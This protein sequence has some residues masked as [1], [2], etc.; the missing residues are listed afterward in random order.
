MLFAIYTLYRKFE[1][2]TG[3]EA[4]FLDLSTDDKVEL[5]K[6]V[7]PFSTYQELGERFIAFKK[8]ADHKFTNLEVG[9]KE[10]VELWEN[11]VNRSMQDFQKFYDT[12]NIHQDYVI[13]ESFYADKGKKIILENEKSW[14][15]CLFTSEI[16]NQQI[17]LL[18]K[19]LDGKTI[20]EK[21]FENT[22][23]EIENDIGSYVVILDNF[24]RFIVLKGN[25]SSIYATRDIWAIN[26]RIQ[27]F[28]PSKIVYVVGQEQKDHFNKLFEFT[29]SISSNKKT[30]FQHI[31]FWFYID[32]ASKKKLSSR[33]WASN[34][35]K[36]LSESIR[37]FKNKYKDND[38]FWEN[39]KD[40]IAKA[41]WVGSIV[42]NDIKKDKKGPVLIDKDLNKTIQ[43]FEEAWWAYII[44]ASC[45]AKSILKRYG[46]ELPK[47]HDVLPEKLEDIEINLI[48]KINQFP[49]IIQQAGENN[50]PAVLA[51]FLY[52][53]AR[54]YNAYYTNHQVLKGD[55][56]HRLLITKCVAQV[57]D[58][59]MKI[60]HIQPLERI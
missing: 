46:K 42:Y 56:N 23:R 13:G 47:L 37:Y 60:C 7:G 55:N 5:Q 33:E 27:G 18:Q 1:K 20:S 12:L 38:E 10:E 52:T 30:D 44:Y 21:E 34:V 29:N 14:K 25:Q 59:G 6:F 32:E 51:E 49:L 11:I 54:E 4:E 22:K 50:D 41:L 53:I 36:I 31:Y 45:R 28:D 15:V 35:N 3:S 39:E 40:T 58:N 9:K 24:E 57:I 2:I 43:K 17:K 16:A 26:Y 19:Q 8:L 48:N